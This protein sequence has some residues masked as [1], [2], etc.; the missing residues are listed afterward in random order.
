MYAGEPHRDV[1]NLRA[2]LGGPTQSERRIGSH[3]GS[4]LLI[5]AALIH[6]GNNEKSIDEKDCDLL[7]AV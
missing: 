6:V 2:L 7:T 5:L 4:V 3:L 1:R